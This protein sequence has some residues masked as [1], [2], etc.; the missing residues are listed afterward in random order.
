VRLLIGALK[1]DP[2]TRTTKKIS[3]GP[4]GTISGYIGTSIPGTG[5]VNLDP[6]FDRQHRLDE[7]EAQR[8]SLLN[9]ID[10]LPQHLWGKSRT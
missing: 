5:T 3:G 6:L 9:R 7:I 2:P 4:S 1:A 10:T 8:A